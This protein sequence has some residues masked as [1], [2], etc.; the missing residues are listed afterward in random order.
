LPWEDRKSWPDRD[1]VGGPRGS[2]PGYRNLRRCAVRPG[3]PS[4]GVWAGL[5]PLPAIPLPEIPPA[6]KKQRL[7]WEK[8]L[9]GIYISEHPLK[10]IQSVLPNISTPIKDLTMDEVGK[11]VRLA[12]I[13]TKGDIIRG[14]LKKLEIEYQ[15]EE[16][17]RYRASH[18]FE[19]IV[20]DKTS[21][22]FQYN[23]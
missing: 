8:E 22:H 23:Y 12:G 1:G 4:P 16:I 7:A 11:T 5:N 21:I 15:A 18:I 13:L 9:L 14:L 2:F 19:D 10:E 3:S 17:H 6:D 20:A